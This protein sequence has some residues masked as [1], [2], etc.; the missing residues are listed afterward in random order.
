MKNKTVNNFIITTLGCKVN[1]YESE[2]IAQCLKESGLKEYESYT[3]NANEKTVLCIINTC[4]VTEK[5]SGRSRRA[6]RRAIRNN[7]DAC[8][9]VTGCLAQIHPDEIKKIPGVD[10][11]IGNAEKYKIPEIIDFLNNKAC[12]YTAPIQDNLNHENSFEHPPVVALGNRTRQFLKIQ[13]GC[14]TFCTYC[15]VPYTRGRSRSMPI[16]NVLENIKQLAKA[17]YREVVLTGIHLGCWGLDLSPKTSLYELLDRIQE[18][19][20]I[21][22]VRL[23]SIEPHELTGD[24]IK[25][26]SKSDIFCHHFHIPLQ[27]GNDFILKKMKRPYSVALF[28]DL[29]LAIYEAMPDAATG[30]DILTGFPGETDAAFQNTYSVI[31]KLPVTYLHVFPFSSREKTPASRYTGKVPAKIIQARCHKMRNLGIHKKKE[32]YK[33]FTGKK[34]EVLIESKRD[35]STGFLKG[36][37][38]NYLPVLL[39]GNDGLKNRI[40]KV[41]IDTINDDL[42]VFG[43][44]EPDVE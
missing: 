30:V 6:V 24:I 10:H 34:V 42:N 41:V 26:V 5:A 19:V 13:D 32:F 1:Q 11:I 37:T 14:N 9:I 7:P 33:K 39:R 20:D 28:H 23:S 12:I 15:I 31:E 36:I 4:T 35:L 27:S 2:V 43:S 3:A 21:D 17:G 44:V 8:I 18:S 29:V 22:R 25:L 38:S 16:E 40:V